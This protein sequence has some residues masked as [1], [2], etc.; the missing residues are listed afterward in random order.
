MTAAWKEDLIPAIIKHLP[1]Q[2][3]EK[4]LWPVV[5]HGLQGCG[6]KALEALLEAFEEKD[7]VIRRLKG[8]EQ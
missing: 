4:P 2:Y 1:P 6:Q 8:E 5:R 7:G 3:Q